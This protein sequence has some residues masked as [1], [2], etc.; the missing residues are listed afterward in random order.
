MKSK[1]YFTII[2]LILISACEKNNLHSY[3]QFT[4]KLNAFILNNYINDAKHL[5]FNE[6]FNDDHHFN[7]NNPI[8]DT[9]EI[10]QVLRII[11]AVYNTDVP[12][13]DTVF[14]IYKIHNMNWQSLNSINLIVQPGIPE[15]NN[16]INGISPTGNKSLDKLLNT[17]HFDFRKRPPKLR[18]LKLKEQ[19]D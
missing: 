19:N 13:R 18:E 9:N 11:Q 12:Q 15:I 17:Y 6:I 10:I 8:L 3:E 4:A 5:Y 7:R 2:F 1:F 14:N 16:L